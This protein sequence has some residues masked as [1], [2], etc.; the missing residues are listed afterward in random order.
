[1]KM[2]LNYDES[3]IIMD[4]LGRLRGEHVNSARGAETLEM[5]DR[6]NAKAYAVA[7]LM[8]RF[9]IQLKARKEGVK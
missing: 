7:N 2:E 8:L 6:Y 3:A 5:M 9:E 4:A 1:M